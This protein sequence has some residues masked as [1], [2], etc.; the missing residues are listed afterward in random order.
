MKVDIVK[1]ISNGC[2]LGWAEGKTFFVPFTIPGETVEISNFVKEKG[3]F[4]ATGLE[5]MTASKHRRKPLCEHYTVCGGCSFQHISYPEQMNIKK[6]IF[7]ELLKQN[8]I[9]LDIEPV[10]YSAGETNLRTRAKVFVTGGVPAFRAYRSNELVKFKNCPLLNPEFV[11]KIFDDSKKRSGDIQYEYSK[12]SHD[13]MPLMDSVR[14]IVNGKTIKILRNSFFQSSEEG[15]GILCSLLEDEIKGSRPETGYDLFCGSGLFSVFMTDAGVKTTGMEIVPESCRSYEEN[16]G[17]T[18]KI[19]RVDAY[20]IKKLEKRDIVVADP[21]RDG[22]GVEL[23]DIIAE[24]KVKTVV[25]VSCEPS[26][27]ARDMKRFIDCGYQ[28]KKL[29]IVDLF[30]STHH[31]EVF[32]VFKRSQDI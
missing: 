13:F 17:N 11:E 15:A 6:E 24:S 29:S 32:S 8:G 31:F 9:E 25:Y 30:P 21:P 26:K 20:K 16:L 22:L 19:E 14:K 1:V 18:A 28:L 12:F 4:K 5:I 3:H 10:L 7:L 23:V 27:F 2:G